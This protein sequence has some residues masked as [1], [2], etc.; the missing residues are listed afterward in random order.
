MLHL[1]ML[2]LKLNIPFIYLFQAAF[3]KS[4]LGADSALN[5]VE[6]NL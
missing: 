4:S 1:G 3:S 5:K 2:D 6:N